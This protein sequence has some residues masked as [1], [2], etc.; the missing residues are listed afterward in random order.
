MNVYDLP[1]INAALN[2]IATVL[3]GSGYVAIKRGR[4]DLHKALMV[5]ALVVSAAFLACYLIYHYHAGSKPFP[6]LGWIKTVY[7][8]IL[9][10]HII[11]A[12][13]MVPMILKTFWHAF[14]GE[15]ERHKKI[16]RWTFPIWMYVSLTG[17]V[18]YLMLYQW[19]A[20]AS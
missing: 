8:L 10:P 19:F 18:I 3:L 5:S 20:P 15:W 12:A 7:L 17:V 6:D 11:L 13:V 9:V 16:A 2:G 1:P 14:R 4:K